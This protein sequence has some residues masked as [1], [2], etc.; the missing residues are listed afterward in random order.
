MKRGSPRLLP[1]GDRRRTIALFF[2]VQLVVGIVLLTSRSLFADSPSSSQVLA[3]S[4][5]AAPFSLGP[6]CTVDLAHAD[7]AFIKGR[8][9]AMVRSLADT[10]PWMGTM[11][12][13]AE[14]GQLT[15]G[16]VRAIMGREVP[17]PVDA[18][19]GVQ[20]SESVPGVQDVHAELAALMAASLAGMTPVEGTAVRRQHRTT[21]AEM[22]VAA[23]DALN[24]TSSVP[25][26]IAFLNALAEEAAP[27]AATRVAVVTTSGVDLRGVRR[28]VL[29]WLQYHTEMGVSRFYIVYNGHDAA[30]VQAL[31]TIRHVR[32]IHVHEPWAKGVDSALVE[33]YSGLS[34]QWKGRPG[35]YALMVTQGFGEHEG[36]RRAK[37]DGMQ[38]LLHLD[39][40]ELVQPGDASGS[41]AEVLGR[42][43]PHVASLRFMNF[44]GQSEAGDVVN[45]YEQVTLFRVHKHFI[46]PEAHWYR[47]RFKLGASTSFLLL[48]A[49][50]K[51]AVRVDAPG[52]RHLG[53]HF[54]TGDPSPRWQ[55]A[56]NP[57][58]E[59]TNLVSDDS[60]IL[61]YPYS[62][63]S[64][65]VDKAHR[66]CP[67]SYL[68]AARA[69]DRAKVRE[70]FVIEA[71]Q[72]AYM[73]AAAGPT[74]VTDF[75]YSRFVLSE[76]VSVRCTD[77]ET[78]LK[79]WCELKDV[80]RLKHLLQK[81]GLFRRISG[82]SILL[83]QH[84]RA[85]QALMHAGSALR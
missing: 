52:V 76:G 32:L 18:R 1:S 11:M 30:A 23:R 28:E 15:R 51:A 73:A 61:H 36:L 9:E 60:V 70:C 84:E 43:P 13:S 2:A 54:W 62:Y 66:S 64:D 38:W 72:D 49:N 34:R 31:E 41:L 55:S 10:N 83:R 35:N 26:R 19:Y 79:G 67:D 59:F 24:D 17:L 20:S 7:A 4:R 8:V 65:V 85:I 44:E 81:I 21:T 71:D 57:G 56:D 33:L 37:E 42:V 80:E 40:D 53:P 48:Y 58:G 16:E 78:K 46:T 27:R 75:F 69:G 68:A 29:P 25:A 63:V 77:P 74:A 6:N 5:E 22:G 45:R 39:P 82:P 50:G 14:E 12:E 3:Q 47:S